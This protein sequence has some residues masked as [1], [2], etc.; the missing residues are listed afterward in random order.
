MIIMGIT[1]AFFATGHSLAKRRPNFK[2]PAG[3]LS[4]LQRLFQFSTDSVDIA[5]DNLSLHGLKL[6]IF[7][8]RQ[9]FAQRWGS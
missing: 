4:V 3:F 8:G 9:H 6:L 1:S 2:R 7:L 5:V